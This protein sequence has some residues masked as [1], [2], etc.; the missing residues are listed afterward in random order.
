MPMAMRVCM[1]QPFLRFYEAGDIR[2]QKR[3]DGRVSTLLEILPVTVDT[4]KHGAGLVTFQPFLRFYSGSIWQPNTLDTEDSVSTLLEILPHQL[5]VSC[6]QKRLQD[7]S[8]LLEI[9]PHSPGCGVAE[10]SRSCVFQ[11][12]LRFYP[13]CGVVIMPYY[14][15]PFQPFLRFYRKSIGRLW[16]KSLFP[17]VSTLLEILQGALALRSQ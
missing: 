12:F 8:T 6:P 4:Y 11:P 17:T 10:Q 3:L 5:Y 13:E 15:W 2:G 7:V 9:L 1:F 16:M 14:V